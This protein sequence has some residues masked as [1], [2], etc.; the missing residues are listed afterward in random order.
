M[1]P[2]TGSIA[3]VLTRTL[4]LL[5]QSFFRITFYN[6]P[7]ILDHC[8]QQSKHSLQNKIEEW[9]DNGWSSHQLL[10]SRLGKKYYTVMMYALT[11]AAKKCL[12]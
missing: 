12:M 7:L 1:F 2:N 4:R 6:R 5:W 3:P 9:N 10:V 11:E 8:A